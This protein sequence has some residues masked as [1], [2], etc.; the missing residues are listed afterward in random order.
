MASV[1]LLILNHTKLRL[2][3]PCTVIIFCAEKG[4]SNATCDQLPSIKPVYGPQS[5]QNGGYEC[6]ERSPSEEGFDDEI[7]LKPSAALEELLPP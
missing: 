5:F 1:E 7:E 4:W 6:G 3:K 2:S